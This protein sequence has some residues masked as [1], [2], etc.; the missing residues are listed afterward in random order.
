MGRPAT[1]CCG[2]ASTGGVHNDWTHAAD[3]TAWRAELDARVVASELAFGM[4]RF[5][6]R[7]RWSCATA[8]GQPARAAR[9]R[10]TSARDGILLVTDIKTG[11]ARSYTGSASRSRAWRAPAAAA[12]LRSGRPA[13]HGAAGPRWRRCT[14]SPEGRG[15]GSRAPDG[16]RAAAVCRHC[17]AARRVGGGGGFSAA[18]PRSNRTSAGCSAP[19][20][21]PMAS[22]TRRCGNSGRRNV[23]A[24]LVASPDP[25][26]AGRRASAGGDLATTTTQGLHDAAARRYPR[27]HGDYALCRGRCRVGQDHTSGRPNADPRALTMESR[28]NT[29]RPSPSPSRPAPNS[30]TA[31]GSPSSAAPTDAPREGSEDRG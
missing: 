12:R 27:R 10:S 8:Q 2:S 17:A 4:K 20:A 26:R 28:S 31:C 1:R 13:A 21:T 18:R 30:A 5:R 9:T 19:T 24:A 25:D 29:S 7:S 14:G 3:D 15:A 23:S 22:D 11:S 16:G 6:T